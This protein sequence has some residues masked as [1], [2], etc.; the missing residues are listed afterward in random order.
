MQRTGTGSNEMKQTKKKLAKI[1]WRFP[2]EDGLVHDLNLNK[3][4]K[5]Y[6][7]GCSFVSIT[8]QK[9]ESVSRCLPR[10][11][12]QKRTSDTNWGYVWQTRRVEIHRQRHF[13]RLWCGCLIGTFLGGAFRANRKENTA[14][15]T[16]GDYPQKPVF[17][18]IVKRKW[19][20]VSGSSC[21]AAIPTCALVD[22]DD[23]D[24]EIVLL[25]SQS[26]GPIDGSWMSG[27][28]LL[29]GSLCTRKKKPTQCWLSPGNIV[30]QI[31]ELV[32]AGIGSQR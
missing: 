30:G 21:Y 24:N 9:F 20:K 15:L 14:R 7:P 17:G 11:Q 23:D 6:R 16:G 31:I 2:N 10:P 32:I 13:F 19:R 22:D 12:S 4:S 3:V 1:L 26:P 5:W 28:F 18:T 29:K 8:R 25:F 27:T